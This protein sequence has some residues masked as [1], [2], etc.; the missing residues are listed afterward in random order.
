MNPSSCHTVTNRS[1]SPAY[2]CPYRL[3]FA[4]PD[5]D[6]LFVDLIGATS[7]HQLAWW[8]NPL[9][10]NRPLHASWR[11][12]TVAPGFAEYQSKTSRIIPLFELRRG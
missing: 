6:P 3:R 9:G 1:Q 2:A 10:E 8:E 4:L 5:D 11:L 7:D 12:H